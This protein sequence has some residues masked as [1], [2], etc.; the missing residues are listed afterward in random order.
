MSEK[1]IGKR[2]KNLLI[3]RYFLLNNF[4]NFRYCFSCIGGWDMKCN[5]VSHLS[6]AIPTPPNTRLRN[7]IFQLKKKW[8]DT[9]IILLDFFNHSHRILNK[10]TCMTTF[11]LMETPPWSSFGQFIQEAAD[12]A[13]ILIWLD[14]NAL[15]DEITNRHSWLYSLH[16]RKENFTFTSAAGNLI[17]GNLA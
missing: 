4:T 10:M 11:N 5:I 8:W 6:Q 17:E 1:K 15:Q 3:T 14:K 12:T 13:V 16:P 9:K 7:L 2:L